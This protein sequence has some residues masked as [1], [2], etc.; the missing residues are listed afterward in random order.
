MYA[1]L[2]IV[3][4]VCFSYFAFSRRRFDLF[5]I[6]NLGAAFYMLPLFIGKVP[7]IGVDGVLTDQLIPLDSR[8]YIF[9]FAVLIAP[10]V[11]AILYDWF[12]PVARKQGTGRSYA[13][14]YLLFAL[15]GIAVHAATTT[16]M[17]H[18]NKAIA[19]EQIG[20]FFTL[21]ETA[22]CLAIL[23]AFKNRRWALLACGIFFLLLD[24]A[25]GFRFNLVLVAIGCVFLWLSEKGLAKLS[26]RL[27][28]CAMIALLILVVGVTANPVRLYGGKITFQYFTVYKNLHDE[29]FR[30]EPFVTQSIANEIFRNELSCQ[31]YKWQQFVL[32]PLPL[33][34]LLDLQ[35]ELFEAQYKQLFPHVKFGLAGNPWAEAFCRNGWIGF[36]LTL[37]FFTGLLLVL[38][39]AFD[40]GVGAAPAVALCGVIVAFYLHRNDAY[41]LAILLRRV[42]I[43]AFLASVLNWLWLAMRSWVNRYPL[44]RQCLAPS[45]L[46]CILNRQGPQVKQPTRDS[47]KGA[48]DRAP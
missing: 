21:F 17:F 8:L 7:K 33:G 45:V 32:L 18:I 27:H 37:C 34:R 48:S 5:A 6:A 25:I 26:S 4:L 20:F 9:G 44:D 14:W 42:V 2:A 31:P 39:L 47:L 15:M 24:V 22:T 13:G 30:L 16:G 41:F 1:A 29:F 46:A 43:L 40:L 10:T 3:E 19:L 36:A 38:Q 28:I 12:M 11:T 23:D 35:P